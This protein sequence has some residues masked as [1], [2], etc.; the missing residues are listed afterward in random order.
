MLTSLFFTKLFLYL[1]F[2]NN[3]SIRKSWKFQSPNFRGFTVL[4]SETKILLKSTKNPQIPTFQFSVKSTIFQKLL[5]RLCRFIS[6]V[7][8]F[9][10][11][12]IFFNWTFQKKI[13]NL[14][15]TFTLHQTISLKPSKIKSSFNL[16]SSAQFF[17]PD[18]DIKSNTMGAFNFH[19]F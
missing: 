13:Q 2:L 4:N 17:S 9:K 5:R 3:F 8:H 12:K 14:Q 10:A 18:D 6:N 11:R 19:Y 7:S 15:K 16:K 1:W